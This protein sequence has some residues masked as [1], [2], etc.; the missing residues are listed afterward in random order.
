MGDP[1]REPG[2][3]SRYSPLALILLDSSVSGSPT[4]GGGRAPHGGANG[5]GTEGKSK[6]KACGH[7][8]LPEA[9][10]HL[11]P[12]HRTPKS[13]TRSGEGLALSASGRTRGGKGG[14]VSAGMKKALGAL[15]RV[16][17]RGATR[18]TRTI[19][20]RSRDERWTSQRAR[21]GEKRPRLWR[22]TAVRDTENER[23][24]VGGREEKTFRALSPKLRCLG[25]RATRS[26]PGCCTRGLSE[27]E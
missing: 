4:A 26:L 12:E 17:R 21:K 2:P 6:G 19:R 13:L 10:R 23:G 3:F 16:P 25:L 7:R 18:K 9:Q 14:T 5:C 11:S 8:V 20:Q 1:A 27:G 24:E 15:G 22:W